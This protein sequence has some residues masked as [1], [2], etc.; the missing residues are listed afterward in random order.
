[1]VTHVTGPAQRAKNTPSVGL[2]PMI[3]WC[4]LCA[5]GMLPLLDKGV[6]EMS[7]CAAGFIQ[8]MYAHPNV[9]AECKIVSLP[10]VLFHHY[11]S[12]LQSHTRGLLS[13]IMAD[14]SMLADQSG[15]SD[16]SAASIT[17]I[18]PYLASTSPILNDADQY[19][20][21]AN[22]STHSIVPP[23]A[24]LAYLQPDTPMPSSSRH[25]IQPA[26]IRPLAQVVFV[27]FTLLL[28]DPLGHQAHRTRHLLDQGPRDA[29]QHHHV[30]SRMPTKAWV[31]ASAHSTSV[32]LLSARAFCVRQVRIC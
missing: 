24:A 7:L 8:P 3:F 14:P 10:P 32:M 16:L 22:T 20:E 6:E 11:R 12:P 2:Q 26:S 1:M 15:L 30:V 9:N 29:N 25:L 17:D 27:R 13:Q 23:A 5:L 18:R 19:Q 21:Q 31:Q 28:L 4:R